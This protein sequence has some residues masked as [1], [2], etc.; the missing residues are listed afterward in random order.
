MKERNQLPAKIIEEDLFDI[1]PQVK[2]NDSNWRLKH[3]LN[4]KLYVAVI[5]N[6]RD[7]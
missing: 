1:E 2:C 4:S 5:L 3:Q 7:N 6:V